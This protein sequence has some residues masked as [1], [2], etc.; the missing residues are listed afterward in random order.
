[1]RRDF[2]Y[3]S[4]LLLIPRFAIELIY[5][6]VNTFLYDKFMKL[7]FHEIFMKTFIKVSSFQKDILVS[8]ILPKNERENFNFCPSLLG[9]KFIVRSKYQKD[10][11]K[12]TA[13]FSRP[14]FL[15]MTQAKGSKPYPAKLLAVNCFWYLTLT[16]F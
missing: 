14:T 5:N 12:L 8:S 6:R 15:C 16:M 2:L 9:Q 1:M 10:I 13:T 7:H 11:S 4:L 3:S